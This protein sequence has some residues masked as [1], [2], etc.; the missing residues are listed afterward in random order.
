MNASD[1]AAFSLS[2]A[3]RVGVRKIFFILPLFHALEQMDIRSV[4]EHMPRECLSRC[5]RM[6]GEHFLFSIS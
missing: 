2:L 4:S 3:H 1:Y 6:V 5:L